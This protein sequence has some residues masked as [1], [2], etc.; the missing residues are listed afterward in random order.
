MSAVQQVDK[1][2][3][4]K[5]GGVA[6]VASVVA[7]LVAFFILNAILD[8]PVA[9]RFSAVECWGDWLFNGRVHLP[10][11]CCLLHCGAGG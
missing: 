7:N 4:W 5:M 3:I 1:S 8:L 10:G 9:S 11:R 6:I 2:K